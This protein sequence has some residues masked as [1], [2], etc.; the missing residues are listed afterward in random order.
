M[1]A[2]AMWPVKHESPGCRTIAI[3]LELLGDRMVGRRTPRAVL[4]S[5]AGR[6]CLHSLLS[7]AMEMEMLRCLEHGYKAVLLEDVETRT[8]SGLLVVGAIGR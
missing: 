2:N 1:L 7:I 3:H 8:L 5:K 4:A 6:A